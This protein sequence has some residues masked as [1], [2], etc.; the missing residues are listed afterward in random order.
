MSKYLVD[1]LRSIPNVDVTTRYTVVAAGNEG[2]LQWLVIE[3]VDTGERAR[4][5]ADA[6]FVFIGATPS[7]EWLGDAIARDE[8]GFVIAGIDLLRDG[9]A[10]GSRWSLAREPYRLETSL[11]GVFVAGDVRKGSVKRI[12]SAVGEG[13]MAVQYIHHYRKNG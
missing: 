1:R 8:D 3:N 13:A 9:A 10:N 6:L 2:R 11:P 5:P 12:A 7:T 4:V